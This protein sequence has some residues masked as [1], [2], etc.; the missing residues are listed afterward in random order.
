ML[1][2]P[3]SADAQQ[4][5]ASGVHWS[6]PLTAVSQL[7]ALTDQGIHTRIGTLMHD[8]DELEDLQALVQRVKANILGGSSAAMD[9]KVLARPAN[10]AA[11]SAKEISSRHPPL[12]FT[13]KALQKANLLDS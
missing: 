4:T 11:N 3:A 5:F 12:M 7:K 2:V 1:T 9:G 13:T 6:H 10:V 8:I